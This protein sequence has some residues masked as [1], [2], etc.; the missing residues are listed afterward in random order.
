ML[1]VA[2]ISERLKNMSKA[3]THWYTVGRDVCFMLNV[4]F[5]HIIL[6]MEASELSSIV[7]AIFGGTGV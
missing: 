7:K 5:S 2:F 1:V 6:L 3:S 4:V